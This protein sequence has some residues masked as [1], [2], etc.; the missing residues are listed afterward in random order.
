VEY[1][2]D[3]LSVERLRRDIDGPLRFWRWW[4]RNEAGERV[5][6]STPRLIVAEDG[7]VSTEDTKESDLG[8]ARPKFAEG[9]VCIKET[10]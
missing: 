4:Y 3:R 1:A 8:A 2:N 6:C 7:F 10:S 5:T 9:I